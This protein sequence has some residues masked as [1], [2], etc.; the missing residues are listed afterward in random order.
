MELKDKKA[1]SREIVLCDIEKA[2]EE[3]VARVTATLRSHYEK[4]MSRLE[5]LF[6]DNQA[7]G[8]KIV[9]LKVQIAEERSA[10][11]AKL[12]QDKASTD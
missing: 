1:K 12:A 7:Q 4:E 2:K 5:G 6:R 9:L 10:T 3:E 8:E 11:E